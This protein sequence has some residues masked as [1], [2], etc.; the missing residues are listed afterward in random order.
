MKNHSFE[1]M[2][3]FEKADLTLTGRGQAVL[4]HA[5]VVTN[6]FFRLTGSRPVLGRLFIASDDE[7]Q[8]AAAVVVTT[9]FWAKT[10]SADPQI[11]GK[12]MTLNGTAYIVIGVLGRD[13]GFFLQPIDYY[14]PLRPT[15]SQASN[16]DAH[17][18]MR[19]L[20]L[21]NPG[22]TLLQARS[23]LDTTMQ[24]LALKDPGP[25]GDH[26]AFAEFLT[27]QRTGDLRHVFVLLM[28]SVCA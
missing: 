14:L 26:R 10:L 5:G 11:I 18:D 13:P 25:E 28:A 12:T 23:D 8:A 20:G 6:E 7:P 21:L 19:V 22:V 9:A 15:A 17:G 24:R 16:R 2:A 3:A 4:T 1:S 27:N